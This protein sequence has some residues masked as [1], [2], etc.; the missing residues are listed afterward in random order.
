MAKTMMI[1]QKIG[2]FRTKDTDGQ[3]AFDKR[4]QKLSGIRHVNV[5]H[6]VLFRTQHSHWAGAARP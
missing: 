4:L 3:A 1:L 6:A 5:R 2:L